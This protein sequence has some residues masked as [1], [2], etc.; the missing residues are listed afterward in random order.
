MGLAISEVKL[1]HQARVRRVA[2]ESRKCQNRRGKVCSIDP[3]IAG[4]F[5]FTKSDTAVACNV[6]FPFYI[7]ASAIGAEDLR[8]MG[9]AVMSFEKELQS[10]LKA[11]DRVCTCSAKPA[12]ARFCNP[13]SRVSSR[14]C[15]RI[16]LAEKSVRIRLAVSKYRKAH[17][18]PKST[19]DGRKNGEKRKQFCPNCC[20]EQCSNAKKQKVQ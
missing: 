8:R 7:Q 1:R 16:A 9:T 17:E 20:C 18:V 4:C 10:F 6:S 13:R 12:V 5:A 2:Q 15:L 11:L 3:R 19:D 14:E